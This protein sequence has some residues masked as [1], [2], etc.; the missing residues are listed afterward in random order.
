MSAF[1]GIGNAPCS[2]GTIE[3][4]EG[5]RVPFGRMLDELVETGYTGTELGDYGYMPTDPARL[6]DE[7]ASR[8]LTML[9]AFE[10]VYL[11]DPAEHAPGRDRALRTAR[12]LAAVAHL[13]DPS[14]RPVL[15]LSDENNRDPLRARTA[16]RVGREASLDDDSFRAFAR[17]AE[18]IARA[19]LGETG[20][21]TVFHPHCAG[22]VE[23]PVE[24]D[25]FLTLTDPAL[26][27][28]VFDTGHILYGSGG[29]EPS[30]VVESLRRFA[31]RVTYVHFKDCSPEVAGRARR[32]GWD[33]TTAVGRGVFCE[34]GRGAVDFRAVADQLSAQGYSGWITVEQDVLPGM[35]TPRESA[36]RNREHLRTLGL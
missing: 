14:W 16:G 9:G 3:G 27:N 10:G 32:E 24:I 4:R 15:V 13:G 28:I 22:Y 23:T 34:L 30:I 18:E 2:W 33:Y 29:N 1:A 6:E 31:E 20:L 5:E 8:E 12:L 35:G 26:L 7:L 11:A 21:G 17:G 19:V 25:R 36:A